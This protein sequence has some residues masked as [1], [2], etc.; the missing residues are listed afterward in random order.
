MEH[1]DKSSRLRVPA[2]AFSASAAQRMRTPFTPASS[3]QAASAAHEEGRSSRP[4]ARS[5]LDVPADADAGEPDVLRRATDASA[6]ALSK[7]PPNVTAVLSKVDR[8][9]DHLLGERI[10]MI[11]IA[12]P[13]PSARSTARVAP[14]PAGVATGSFPVSSDD[15]AV[16]T[17]AVSPAAASKAGAADVAAVA[18]VQDEPLALSTKLPDESGVVPASTAARLGAR[19]GTLSTTTTSLIVTRPRKSS[20][21]G[22]LL[23]LLGVL[24]AVLAWWLTSGTFRRDSDAAGRAVVSSAPQPQ[25]PAVPSRPDIIVDVDEVKQNP[26]EADAVSTPVKAATKPQPGRIR[27][28]DVTN[29]EH[30]ESTAVAPQPAQS[31]PTKTAPSDEGPSREQVLERMESVRSAVQACAGA[32]SG[33]AELDMTIASSGAVTYVLVGGDFAGTPEGSCISR[34]VRTAQFPPFKKER[35]RVLYPY[36]I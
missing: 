33:I 6:A 30:N 36:V 5:L 19:E 11:D 23:V 20:W 2:G 4:P 25:A 22:P 18:A 9:G 24:L 12:P 3:A 15:R 32:H 7:S 14:L 16:V 27:K 28:P 34:A 17:A 10:G 21:L 1:N 35:F 29:L 31:Q 26:S 8:A 13:T